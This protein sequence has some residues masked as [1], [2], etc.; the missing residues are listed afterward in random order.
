MHV[1]L[2]LAGGPAAGGPAPV[3]L[4]L[5]AGGAAGHGRAP[6]WWP[7][8]PASASSTAA[9]TAVLGLQRAAGHRCPLLLGR[10]V[11]KCSQ[12][13]GPFRSPLNR[14]LA[15]LVLPRLRT[16]C[17]RGDAHRGAPARTSGLTN[18]V[19][20][21]DLAFAMEVPTTSGSGSRPPRRPGRSRARTSWCRPSQVVDTLLH[22]TGGSTTPA[23]MAEFIDA[24]VDAPAS[25]W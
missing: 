14:R 15:G 9:G 3:A 4:G 25:R 5:P 19:P 1:P 11:V 10:P 6:T 18:L 2:A 20:A 16:I 7:T 17:P 23:I 21:G 22:G 12:A 24:A 8:S 13:M